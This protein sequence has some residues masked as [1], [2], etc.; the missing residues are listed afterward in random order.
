MAMMVLLQ[1]PRRKC[2]ASTM[3]T[4]NAWQEE[5]TEHTL[6]MLE[7]I[8]RSDVPVARG[9]VYPLVRTEEETRLNTPLVGQVDWLGAWVRVR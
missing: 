5:E 8:G 9:A 2:W 3:V 6:R 4:G 7:L 1:S